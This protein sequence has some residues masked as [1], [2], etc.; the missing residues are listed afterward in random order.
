MDQRS[1]R[2]RIAAARVVD[3]ADNAD[4]QQHHGADDKPRGGHVQHV[5]TLGKTTDHDDHT[6]QID[7]K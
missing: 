1:R 4:T 5:G 7:R 6:E 2:G 3:P